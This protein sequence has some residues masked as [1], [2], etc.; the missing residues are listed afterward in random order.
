[1]TKKGN[2]KS[3]LVKSEYAALNAV[4]AYPSFLVT[5]T[6][7]VYTAGLRGEERW[8]ILR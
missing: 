7:V 5:G 1:M 6:G 8:I 4:K 3:D 2:I